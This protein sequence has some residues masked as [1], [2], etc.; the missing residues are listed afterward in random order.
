MELNDT[1]CEA[2]PDA[3]SGEEATLEE[4]VHGTTP[5]TSV[6]EQASRTGTLTG[7]HPAEPSP[8][9]DEDVEIVEPSQ[10]L[11]EEPAVQEDPEAAL[12]RRVAELRSG[13]TKKS[14]RK[15]SSR[16]SPRR[17]AY[18]FRSGRKEVRQN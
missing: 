3:A 5:E 14:S 2:V 16:K 4:P 6:P 10:S 12:H 15:R 1:H 18:E 13:A 9:I 8:L 11:T 17:S 7:Y